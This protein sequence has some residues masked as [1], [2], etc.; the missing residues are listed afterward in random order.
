M[1]T[2]G[3]F[4]FDRQISAHPTPA[5]VS[6]N[7]NLRF[8]IMRPMKRLPR[9]Q[10]AGD[11]QPS[12][13]ETRDGRSHGLAGSTWVLRSSG[14]ASGEIMNRIIARAASCFV[15]RVNTATLDAHGLFRKPGSGPTY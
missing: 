10:V 15:E 11:R 2:N 1:N 6:L 8:S 12:R 3:R 13:V 4:R 9:R 7:K 14:A 5:T